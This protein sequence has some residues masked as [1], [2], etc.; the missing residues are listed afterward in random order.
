MKSGGIGDGT[1]SRRIRLTNVVG[2]A[3]VLLLMSLLH[4]VPA[5]ALEPRVYSTNAGTC[6][7]FANYADEIRPANFAVTTQTALTGGLSAVEIGFTVRNADSAQFLGATLIPDVNYLAAQLG[8]VSAS[9]VPGTTGAIASRAASVASATPIMLQL[10]TANIATLV[11]QLNSGHVPMTVHANEQMV[12][13]ADVQVIYWNRSAAAPLPDEAYYVAA[14]DQ[15]GFNPVPH[16]P[17]YA[18]GEQF[19]FRLVATQSTARSSFDDWQPGLTRYY[20]NKFQPLTQIP[21][22][23]QTGRILNVITVR[24]TAA[25]RTTWTVT[26][27]RSYSDAMANLYQSA[28]FCSGKTLH[29]DR[30]VHASQL[31]N[32]DGNSAFG[33][34][35]TL[36]AKEV[37]THPQPIRFN[38][39]EPVANLKVSGQVQGHILKPGLEIR[40]RDG[41]LRLVSEFDSDMTFSAEARAHASVSASGE[42]DLYNL[43]FPVS[44]IPAGPITI[45]VNL[46]LQHKVGYAGSAEAEAVTS[47]R[48]RFHHIFKVG[49]DERLPPGQQRIESHQDLSTP[50]DFTPPHL[51]DRTEAHG[52]LYT[53]FLPSIY[54]AIDDTQCL[55]GGRA[56]VDVLGFATADVTPTVEPW[57]R[58]G[59]GA[60]LFGGLAFGAFGLNVANWQTDPVTL[61]GAEARSSPTPPL[62][63]AGNALKAGGM[64]PKNLR[65]AGMDQ[66]WATVIEDQNTPVGFS[67]TSVARTADNGVLVAATVS[68]GGHLVRFD[69][70]GA[71][72]WSVNYR[73]RPVKV[74]QFPDATSTVIG[75]THWIARHSATGAL[76]S[77]H[78][79]DL[80]PADKPATV[81]CRANN[82]AWIQV[83]PGQYDIVVVGTTIGDGDGQACITRV[84]ADGTVAWAKTY[85]GAAPEEANQTQ[86]FNGVTMAR[87]GRIV[88]VGQYSTHDPLNAS[89]GW[90]ARIDA[91]DG[92]IVWVKRI[93]TDRTAK[94][95]AVTEMVDGTLIAVGNGQGG[96]YSTGAAWLARVNADGGDIR[97]AYLIED[98]YWE[99]NLNF[100]SPG[101]TQGGNTAYDELYDIVPMIDG[102]AVAGK[103]GLATG[104]VAAWLAKFNTNL[105]V[106]WFTTVDGTSNDV[107][108]SIAYTPDGLLATGWTGSVPTPNTFGDQLLVMKTS[109][110]GLNIMK[111]GTGLTTRFA[112][113]G[114]RGALDSLV[115]PL[116]T[117]TPNVAVNAVTVRST[118]A[119]ADL[120]GTS[121]RLC[122]TRLTSTGRDSTADVCVGTAQSISF[123]P[124]PNKVYGDP[125]FTLSATGGASG[126]AVSFDTQTPLVCSTIGT[127]GVTVTLLGVGVCIIVASQAGGFGFEAAPPVSQSFTVVQAVP[128]TVK[129]RGNGAGRVRSV[130]IGL[131]CT[132]DCVVTVAAGAQVTLSASGTAG[133]VFVGWL[134]SGCTG[135]SPNCTV[136]VN[137]AKTAYVSFSPE[138]TVLSFD[139]DNSGAPTKFD[140]AS[141]G[142][143][144]VRFLLGFTGDAITERAHVAQPSGRT[145]RE[146]QDYLALIQ[147]T[148]DVDGDGTVDALTD[149][150]LIMRYMLGLRGNALVS[151]ALR[152][153]A[154]RDANAIA[155]YLMELMP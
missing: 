52:K 129:F 153:G 76:L 93:V 35:P 38:D 98:D 77:N 56:Y 47:V 126:N 91:S 139:I 34:N 152:S 128:I 127:N 95:N 15:F 111:A 18:D 86:A 83:S 112:E 66:R 79:Y 36:S 113:P 21:E 124:L 144:I 121:N 37:K 104:T 85:N 115:T 2:K 146:T 154:T 12:L 94:L 140:A 57:W 16:G 141:D 110:A 133:S 78:R 63:A 74:L 131:D 96:P 27:Q 151:G 142:V 40:F 39:Q 64:Q 1:T 41:K 109:H 120:I 138:G 117:V 42:K 90:I 48:K 22:P 122:A 70:H 92:S 75:E 73:W 49:F 54:V 17:P 132:S 148:L 3:V 14:R 32:I 145:A 143:M 7:G 43:C 80:G 137:A 11:A 69:D 114:V 9:L 67:K 5:H 55:S 119:L 50:M 88:A 106:E 10:P 19:T 108:D 116:A 125:P 25:N 155:S 103:T 147:A 61:A 8:A 60:E 118:A 4:A 44:E 13:A 53:R 150:V 29:V 65:E 33:I 89:R 84:A 72:L 30:A 31:F 24:D 59:V 68:G 82:A 123:A 87:D 136:V 71:M 28:G 46:K 102:F 6:D 135:R 62:G 149:G 26:V 107:L 23:H 99:T 101:N 45:N 58:L 51:T 20:L 130:P 81:Y 100:E 134:G 105:G 97:S